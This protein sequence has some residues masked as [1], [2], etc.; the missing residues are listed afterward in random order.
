MMRWEVFWL[1]VLVCSLVGSFLRGSACTREVRSSESANCRHV[2]V[3]VHGAGG[4][5]STAS[6]RTNGELAPGHCCE[7]SPRAL[8]QR[9]PVGDHRARERLQAARPRAE[10]QHF[11]LSPSQE[12]RHAVSARGRAPTERGS[13]STCLLL[14]SGVG[15]FRLLALA[16]M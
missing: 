12:H 8:V 4:S 3:Q 16:R 1:K 5:G 6:Q 14:L 11:C 9:V 13:L 10:S 15:A 2:A 7:E